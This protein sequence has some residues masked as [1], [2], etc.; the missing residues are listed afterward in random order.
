MLKKNH[1]GAR[2]GSGR[3][4][5]SGKFREKTRPIRIPESLFSTVRE[6]LEGYADASLPI[7]TS[8]FHDRIYRPTSNHKKPLPLYASRI[9]AGF[10]TSADE[11]LELELD[12]NE[13]LI[14][15]PKNTFLVRV[16]GDSMIGAGIYA[17]DLLVVDRSLQPIHGKI[18]IA[19]IN[20][21]LTVKR[22]YNN[23]K[24]EI[25]LMAENDH[26]PPITIDDSMEFSI[27]GIV[28][29][30]IHAV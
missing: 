20:G 8:E 23:L 24:G 30:V 7:Q 21:E 1:G 17:N 14:K 9:A 13:Y 3:P 28:T 4:K 29:Y 2:A 5:G 19:V 27:W 25:K 18:I 6:M 22:L 10:P 26:Y 12:L 16:S 15:N 11:H